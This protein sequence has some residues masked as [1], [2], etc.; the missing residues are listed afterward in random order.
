MNNL[1]DVVEP[2][3]PTE[4]IA[5]YWHFLKNVSESERSALG[6]IEVVLKSRT[7]ARGWPIGL[8]NQT[9]AL[10]SESELSVKSMV[11]FIDISEVS[12]VSFYGVHNILPFVTAGAIARSPLERRTSHADVK[13][14]LLHVLE[15]IRQTWP[16]RI[17][18]E[19]DPTTHSVDEMMNLGQVMQATL[20]VVRSFQG[21]PVIWA[22][23]MESKGLHVVNALD[24]K[25]IAITRRENGDIEIAFRFSRA[26]PKNLDDR[27]LSLFSAVF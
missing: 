4:L 5:N 19:T 6:P 16:T 3:A 21:Q 15:D 14:D 11:A 12:S 2:L 26:L 23:L 20:A 24:M 17:Y 25:D 10:I 27:V 1:F 9:L 8:R 18:F 22:E 13:Q 7:V